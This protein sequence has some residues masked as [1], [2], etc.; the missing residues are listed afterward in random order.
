MLNPGIISS[1][2]DRLGKYLEKNS[3]QQKDILTIK[4]ILEI[5][6]MNFPLPMYKFIPAQLDRLTINIKIP[7]YTNDRINEIKYLKY[8][9]NKYVTKYGRCN[10]IDNSVLYGG[11]NLHAIF[12]EMRPDLG[13][14][15]TTS[16]WKVKELKPLNFFPVFFITQYGN[17]PHNSLSLD[18]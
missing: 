1:L 14:N 6:I 16:Q 2:T 13:I 10:V 11:F 17:D 12:N 3:I 8:P 18:I 5:L 15:I 4:P 7:P 9:E